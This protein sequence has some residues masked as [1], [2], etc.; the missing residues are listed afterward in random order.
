MKLKTILIAIWIVIV[1]PTTVFAFFKDTH[2]S[3]GNTF[4]ATTLDTNLT[5][6]YPSPII[7]EILYGGT[8]EQTVEF[9]FILTNTGSLNTQ[10]RLQA[11]D[12]SNP[13]FASKIWL[14]VTMDETTPLYSGYLDSFIKNSYLIQIPTQ[15]NK[16]GFTFSISETNYLATPE[17]TVTFKMQN[18]AWQ[19]T[20]PYGSGFFDNE[21]IELQLTNPLTI[22]S[23]SSSISGFIEY[24]PF[25]IQ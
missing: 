14:E 17:Q 11:I 5:P 23:L 19:T 6:S 4:S 16:V 15:V 3:S 25:N 8:P 1:L 21:Y 20:L 24:N 13:S 22:P 7:R 10:N 9:S 2:T 18:H 12:I